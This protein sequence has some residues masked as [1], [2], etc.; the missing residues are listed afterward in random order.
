M[1][2]ESLISTIGFLVLL[3]GPVIADELETN[4]K[5][6]HQWLCR[7]LEAIGPGE[8][9]PI[10][11]TGILSHGDL[12]DPEEPVCR[13]SVQP[14]TWVEFPA[15][16]EPDPALER[17]LSED[18]RAFVRIQGILFGPALISSEVPEENPILRVS[19]KN[20]LRYGSHLNLRTKLVVEKL[21][22]VRPVPDSVPWN[23]VLSKP[24]S[25][26]AD[27][28]VTRAMMPS[29]PR[30]ARSL[31]VAGAV[32]LVV[33]VEAGQV[34]AVESVNGAPSLVDETI[35]NVKSWQFDQGVSCSF[36]TMFVYTLERRI[37]GSDD[38]PVVEAHLPWIVK[39]TAPTA[40][41]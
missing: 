38:S 30:I 41:W 4:P 11:I 25:Q 10:N 23:I 12:Y 13:M 36:S 28:V 35:E 2:R 3:L 19:E 16:F 5:A 37:M 26:K 24:P 34:T 14:S 6:E 20:R 9:V 7:A 31:G 22:D 1:Q 15:S 21:L 18:H 39:V 17:L 29:Y 32:N 40:D 8:E 27:L 33:T